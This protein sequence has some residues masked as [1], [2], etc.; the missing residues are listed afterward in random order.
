M[1]PVSRVV[2][3]D[4]WIG[5][6]IRRGAHVLRVAIPNGD[7]AFLLALIV[8]HIDQEAVHRDRVCPE[9]HLLWIKAVALVSGKTVRRATRRAIH[10]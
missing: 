6:P 7:R 3:I 5:L 1:W 8:D 10:P 9:L 4:A 2:A